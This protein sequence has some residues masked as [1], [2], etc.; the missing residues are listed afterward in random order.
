MSAQMTAQLIPALAFG[1]V[2]LLIW[3]LVG[4]MPRRSARLQHQLNRFTSRPI[5]TNV[6]H[7]LAT[8]PSSPTRI[9][10][11]ITLTF[12]GYFASSTV[13]RA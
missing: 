8:M 11:R 2:T 10:C 4:W 12:A 5:S 3:G 9:A 1:S 6:S 13:S 7:G